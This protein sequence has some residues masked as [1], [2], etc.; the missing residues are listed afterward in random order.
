MYLESSH[1]LGVAINAHDVNF[2]SYF[3]LKFDWVAIFVHSHE[4]SRF[5]TGGQKLEEL[6]LI[7]QDGLFYI[8]TREKHHND[9][10]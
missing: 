3:H 10:W 2:V 9:A 6:V 8:Q 4:P 1:R 7:T 5:D